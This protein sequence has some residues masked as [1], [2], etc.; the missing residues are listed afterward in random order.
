[1]NLH[2]GVVKAPFYN[3]VSPFP[4]DWGT[5]RCRGGFL[6]GW[7]PEFFH[8]LVAVALHQV[9]ENAAGCQVEPL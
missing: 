5:V 4:A 7:W 8:G 6:A 2:M 3:C 1:M 9:E